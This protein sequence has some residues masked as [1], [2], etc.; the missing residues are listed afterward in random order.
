MLKTKKGPRQSE[1]GTERLIKRRQVRKSMPERCCILVPYS[2]H[3]YPTPPVGSSSSRRLQ[4]GWEDFWDGETIL[5]VCF[6]S[7]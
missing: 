3:P 7:F 5:V 6:F 4:R 2:T 1:E